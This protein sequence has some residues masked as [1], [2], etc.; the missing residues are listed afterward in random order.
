MKNYVLRLALL[1]MMLNF[2]SHAKAEL[3]TQPS[4]LKAGDQYRLVFV[5]S[6]LRNATSNNIAEIVFGTIFESVRSRSRK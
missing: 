5:T 4:G 1:V 2:S 3:I 6:T